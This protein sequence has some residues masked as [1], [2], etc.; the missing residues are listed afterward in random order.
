VV[1]GGILAGLGWPDAECRLA[2]CLAEP[3]A[4]P[5][6][7]AEARR[8]RVAP[9]VYAGLRA[10]DTGM[11]P[12]GVLEDLRRATLAVGARSARIEQ[13]A[14]TILAAASV[15]GIPVLLLKG[16]SLQGLAYPAGIVR[17]M[18][19]VDLLVSPT[20]CPRLGRLLRSRGYRN[21]LRGEED[22]FAPDLSY[23]IDLHTS[24]VNTTRLPARGALWAESF[25]EIWGRRQTIVV[26]G[27]P[28]WTLGP[29]DSIQHLAVH[30]VH[31]HGMHGV[32][33]MADLVAASQTW[34]T[35][36]SA[37][38]HAPMG[39][40][41]SVWYCLEVLAARAQ[42]PLPALRAALRPRRLFPGERR[43]LTLAAQAES[44]GH[45]RYG[46][47]FACL[48]GWIN[49]TAFAK[50]L[51]FPSEPVYA[52]GFADAGPPARRARIAHW[53]HVVRL[54]THRRVRGRPEHHAETGMNEPAVRKGREERADRGA[55]GGAGLRETGRASS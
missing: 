44:P 30:A 51:V 37:A 5:L 52:T 20:D 48:P 46:F 2:A 25:Q 19:D 14:A 36:F 27:T 50:Q 26:G 55:D 43:L 3:V 54:V 15:A 22:F 38:R 12:R 8:S 17:P 7:V 1:W 28:A 23:S 39:V 35:A 4:W 53:G 34:P 11:V 21:D 49:K 16:L 13:A 40:R 9:L 29:Q 10:A 33:W 42:D 6:V 41:R 32:L 45:I 47:T 24:L 31:H 18:D